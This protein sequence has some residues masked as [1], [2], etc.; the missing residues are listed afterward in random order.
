MLFGYLSTCTEKVITPNNF[1]FLIYPNLLRLHC[2]YPHEVVKNI[3][4]GQFKFWYW[5]Q[6]YLLP[7]LLP[8]YSKILNKFFRRKFAQRILFILLSLAAFWKKPRFIGGAFV[9]KCPWIV[10][11]PWESLPT[12]GQM[13][14]SC[15]VNT[16]N[17]HSVNIPGFNCAVTK[18]MRIFNGINSK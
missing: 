11:C 6:F 2:I 1:S 10:K 12:P 14:A 13:S 15:P 4:F 18:E 9:L 7:K 17:D 8:E 5:Q 16:F 3:F